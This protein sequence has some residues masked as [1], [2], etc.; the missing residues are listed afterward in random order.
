ME[1]FI[2]PKQGGLTNAEIAKKLKVSE[3][4]LYNW[5][6][7]PLFIKEYK[8]AVIQHTHH[9]LPAIINAMVKEVEDNGNAAMAKLLL[10]MND[11]LPGSGEAVQ[12]K[13]RSES[14]NAIHSIEAMQ[15]RI[16]E[17]KKR[18]NVKYIPI[19]N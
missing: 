1:Y 14:S 18:Q 19:N 2:Q 9:K 17:Y 10:Q 15:E 13:L 5:K 8:R 6:N 12:D 3:R 7:D 16:R 11:M 4:T